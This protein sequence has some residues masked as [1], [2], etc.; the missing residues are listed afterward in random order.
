MM[1]RIE[2][3]TIVRTSLNSCDA[4]LTHSMM[5]CQLDLPMEPFLVHGAEGT[6]VEGFL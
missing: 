1:L 6:K 5:R 3:R 4:Q 2:I